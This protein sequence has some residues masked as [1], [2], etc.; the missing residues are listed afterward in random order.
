MALNWWRFGVFA[1][2]SF[3]N[4]TSFSSLG[5]KLEYSESRPLSLCGSPGRH[6]QWGQQAETLHSHCPDWLPAAGAAGEGHHGD[7]QA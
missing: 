7:R 4:E 2:L 6:L 5:G 1:C 3:P